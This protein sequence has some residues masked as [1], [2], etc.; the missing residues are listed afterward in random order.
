[1]NYMLIFIIGAFL[2]FLV[3]WFWFNKKEK[4]TKKE[5]GRVE[6]EVQTEREIWYGFSEFNEKMAGIKRER[7]RRVLGELKKV[8]KMRTSG[9]A[10][11]LDISRATAFRYLEELEKEGIIEQIGKTGHEVEYK[12]K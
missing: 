6:R 3:A 2:G 9:V 5:A 11:L 1:M 8:G 12:L 4:E 10:D 7:K